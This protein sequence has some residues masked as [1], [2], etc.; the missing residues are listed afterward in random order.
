M[1][2]VP[3]QTAHRSLPL[4]PGERSLPA[5]RGRHGPEQVPVTTS[6]A[7]PQPSLTHT[8]EGH[9][10]SSQQERSTVLFVSL[11]SYRGKKFLFL[12]RGPGTMGSTSHHTSTECPTS[13]FLYKA[14]LTAGPSRSGMNALFTLKRDSA[15]PGLIHC[16]AISPQGDLGQVVLSRFSAGVSWHR[17][18]KVNSNHLRLRPY[19]P[20][21]H[22]LPLPAALPA[23]RSQLLG[24]FGDMHLAAGT[25]MTGPRA[26][27]QTDAGFTE[28]K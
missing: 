14:L 19:S 5:G 11:K 28:V 4:S 25:G 21:V 6:T 20:R 8:R 27:L 22:S 18:T 26:S 9:L 23:A 17:A 3:V 15:D 24:C 7:A 2:A 16:S 13:S 10:S 1:H 12:S